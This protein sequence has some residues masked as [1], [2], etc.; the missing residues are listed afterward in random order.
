LEIVL[1]YKQ[2][3]T[4]E[5]FEKQLFLPESVFFTGTNL[6][7]VVP[8]TTQ[9]RYIPRRE[10]GILG[11]NS[12]WVTLKTRKN[13]SLRTSSQWISARESLMRNLWK[14]VESLQSYVLHDN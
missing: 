14:A 5:L 11:S 1:F 13:L 4:L 12:A 10:A 6:V 9:E 2:S 8:V 7:L 3:R